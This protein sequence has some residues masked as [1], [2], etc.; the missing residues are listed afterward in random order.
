MWINPV[1]DRTQ[2]DIDGQT[3]KGH[4]KAD[5]LNRIEQNCSYLAGVFGVTVI[6]REWTRTDFPT[7]SETERIRNNIETLRAAYMVYQ[8]TPD[9]PA[10]PPNEYHKVNYLEQ[11]IHDLRALHDDNTRAVNYAGETYSGQLIGVI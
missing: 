9:T 6:T 1:F 7:T 3:S 5:D 11:I 8:T 4:Y 2:A 10:T